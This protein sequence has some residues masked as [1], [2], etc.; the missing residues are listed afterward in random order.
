MRS[1]MLKTINLQS[2]KKLPI[3]ITNQRKF[4]YSHSVFRVKAVKQILIS[5]TVFEISLKSLIFETKDIWIFAPKIANK[6]VTILAQKF[7]YRRFQI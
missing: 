1:T 5:P 3:F 6:I 4:S 2:L 7:K